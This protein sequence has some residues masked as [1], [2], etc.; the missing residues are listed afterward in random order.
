MA[1]TES[2]R[3]GIKEA[4]IAECQKPVACFC[5]DILGDGAPV[6]S[7]KL[8]LLGSLWSFVRIDDTQVRKAGNGSLKLQ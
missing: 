3:K 5:R 4:L 2:R 1:L 7:F 6:M 8:C